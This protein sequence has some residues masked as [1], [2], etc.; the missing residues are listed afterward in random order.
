[1]ENNNDKLRRRRLIMDKTTLYKDYRGKVVILI[2]NDDFSNKEGYL[3][4]D[5][6]DLPSAPQEFWDIVEGKLVIKTPPEIPLKELKAKKKAEINAKKIA[7]EYANITYLNTEFQADADSQFKILSAINFC[8]IKGLKKYEWWDADNQ[9]IELTIE[10]LTELGTLIA[11]R[12]SSL[13]K[14]G[15]TLKDAV[16]IANNKTELENIKWE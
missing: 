10:Q 13:V 11:L 8:A 4:V 6:K 9:K 3:V 5:T 14:K 7:A 2:T 16:N 12:S 15:R 1:V